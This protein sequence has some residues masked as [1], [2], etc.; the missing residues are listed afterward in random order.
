[1]RDDEL[2]AAAAEVFRHFERRESSHKSATI[3][4]EWVLSVFCWDGLLP[5]A[6][7]G[8]PTL[9]QLWMPN[10]QILLGLL[11]VICPVTAMSIRFVIGWQRMRRGQS[12]IWQMVL[13]IVGISSLFLFEMFILNDQIANW[14]KIADPQVL[15]MMFA[16]YLSMMAIALLPVRALLEKRSG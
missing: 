6:V 1:M 3:M 11:F 2:N 10:W 14:P 8:I 5:I 12:Y 13:F 9:V 15:L 4:I 7:V 16:V